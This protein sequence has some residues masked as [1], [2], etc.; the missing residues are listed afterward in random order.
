MR[1]SLQRV[2][3]ELL[4]RETKTPTRMRR[5]RSRTSALS[6]CGS[7][8]PRSRQRRNW[9]AT[10]GD[11]EHLVRQVFEAMGMQGRTTTASNDDGRAYDYPGEARQER[12]GCQ[13]HPASW[14]VPWRRKGR[15]RHSGHH[16]LVYHRRVTEGRR[17]L[18]YGVDRRPPSRLP[19]QRASRQGRPH[20]D[21]ATP[22][23]GHGSATSSMTKATVLN[24]NRIRTPQSDL[25]T[26]E[27]TL[28]TARPAR[29]R[30]R[31]T[32]ELA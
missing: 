6:L 24:E 4:H 3:H 2:G 30:P 32:M 28:Y 20:R 29:R 1:K 14:R 9:P 18:P 27:T 10:H 13:P 15:P 22:E 31:A 16:L 26:I 21:Q 19:H 25:L 7:G 17:A 23:C 11:F 5:C 12:D 8:P